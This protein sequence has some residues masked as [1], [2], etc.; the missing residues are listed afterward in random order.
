MN[1][2]LRA[3]PIAL[4][5]VLLAFNAFLDWNA[6]P[7]GPTAGHAIVRFN[8]YSLL[9]ILS[10]YYVVFFLAGCLGILVLRVLLRPPFRAAFLNSIRV[11]WSRDDRGMFAPA[12]PCS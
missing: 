11:D 8:A 1:C 10:E 3:Y 6:D 4:L 2:D 5:F 7:A 12:A 9:A